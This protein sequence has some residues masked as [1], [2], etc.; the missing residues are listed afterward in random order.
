MKL[1]PKTVLGAAAAGAGAYLGYTWL[2]PEIVTGYAGPPNEARLR[3]GAGVG[4]EFAV[5]GG[6]LAW[7][8]RWDRWAEQNDGWIRDNYGRRAKI[9]TPG[10]SFMVYRLAVE[11]L[12]QS[13]RFARI[14]MRVVRPEPLR[15]MY[16]GF[17][18]EGK[19]NLASLN[20]GEIAVLTHY[21]NASVQAATALRVLSRCYRAAGM[22]PHTSPSAFRQRL[23][24]ITVGG[25]INP[26]ANHDISPPAKVGFTVE[27]RNGWETFGLQALNAYT[28][29][30]PE[31]TANLL[32]DSDQETLREDAEQTGEALSQPATMGTPLLAL[33][34]ILERIAVMLIG[35]A[36]VIV[37]EKP[38]NSVIL[39]L[40]GNQEYQAAL[41][42]RYER[43]AERCDDGDQEACARLPE[44]SAEIKT[45]RMGWLKKSLMWIMIIT[46][47]GGLT[48]G[49]YR[50]TVG[51]RKRIGKRVEKDVKRI[52]A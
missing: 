18:N 31:L 38:L 2:R 9:G 4:R 1:E 36:I 42:D 16:E 44:L 40:F 25:E 37:L 52:T 10:A 29:A 11:L 19:Y 48:Y 47:V 50:L 49:G 46:V 20:D 39:G 14:F 45:F 8:N 15:L 6:V 27:G 33:L 43:L 41:A 28:T 3:Q 5:E 17:L 24:T 34:P 21:V 32:N 35:L 51:R 7:D 12:E 30:Y 13:N 26:L 23:T 22:E